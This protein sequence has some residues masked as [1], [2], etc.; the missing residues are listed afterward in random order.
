MKRYWA[1]AGE[2]YYPCGG[3]DDFRESFDTLEKAKQS[4]LE[5]DTEWTWWHI[6]DRETG[7][8]VQL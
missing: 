1:F 3:G 6:V 8:K 7:K 2:F 5:W 4:V